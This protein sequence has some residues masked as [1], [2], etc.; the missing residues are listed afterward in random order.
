[1]SPQDDNQLFWGETMRRQGKRVFAN[2]KKRGE[3][4]ELLFMTVAA[5]LGFNVAKPWGDSAS[6]DVVVENEGR[7]LR[8]QVKSTEMWAAGCYL[9]Q[10]HAGGNRLYTEKEIDYFAIYVLPEDVWYIFPV[11]TLV[12]MSAVGLT[13]NRATSKYNRYKENWWY[14]TRHHFRRGARTGVPGQDQRPSSIN[15]LSGRI[16]KRIKGGD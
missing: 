1:M 13:P 6:Y 2:Y 11:K 9:C 15:R 16:M 5:G 10:L 8:I 7:F 3:W 4:A 14:L 12:G